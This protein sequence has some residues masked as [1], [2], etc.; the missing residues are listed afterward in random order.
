M[1][2]GRTG[3]LAALVAAAG[4]MA[5]GLCET[6]AAPRH[7]G[8]AQGTQGTRAGAA[9][10]T[11]SIRQGERLNQN[12][13][14]IVSG[15]PNG[16][17]L[18][19]AYDMSAVLDDAERLR[20]LPVVGKGGAQNIRDVLFLKG[21]DMGITQ[22]TDLTRLKRDE[23]GEAGKLVYLTKLYNEEVHVLARGEVRTL[24]DLDGKA[25]NF[26]DIGGG[27]QFVA[28]EL[29]EKSGV[30]V[31]EVNMG[32]ADAIEKMRTGEVAA[33]VF[34]AGKPGTAFAKAPRDAGLHFLPVRYGAAF[35]ESYYPAALE[36]A[37]YPGLIGPGER[38]ETI[39]VGAVLVAFNWPAKTDRYRRL[40]TFVD[41][42]FS[43]FDGF[44]AAPRHP[45]WREVNLATDVPGWR[46]F[47]PARRW[48]AERSAAAPAAGGDAALK[49]EFDR[50]AAGKN[51]P[52][53]ERERMFE[54]FLRWREKGR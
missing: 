11:G 18:Q 4:L 51:L 47:E 20:V 39:A 45:K 38:V 24:K 53:G 14:A 42:F 13:V 12:T 27:T 2:R 29:F 54:E 28:R 41:A 37:D 48:L 36:A 21:V 3:V 23:P 6:E 15:N 22:S 9:A 8:K 25:V 35:E 10:T 40:E 30:S 1:I 43:K 46:R 33:T 34:V 44:Q 19:V 32:Q 17:Y 31:R 16:T 7:S 49:S 26:S 52:A 50:F 5:A